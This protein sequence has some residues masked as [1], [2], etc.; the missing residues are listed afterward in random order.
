MNNSFDAATL[1]DF[2]LAT[3]VEELI[4]RAI[5]VPRNLDFADGISV[6]ITASQSYRDS[7]YKIEHKVSV[8][9]WSDSQTSIT[10]N[11]V[12]SAHNAFSRW[13]EDKTQEP[14]TIRPLLSAPKPRPEYTDADFVDLGGE[15][16]TQSE[17]F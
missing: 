14:T 5:A 9:N 17:T 10:N 13:L 2:Q 7:E 6:S 1:S 4:K 8:G 15:N 16:A 11:A 3:C 12:Q